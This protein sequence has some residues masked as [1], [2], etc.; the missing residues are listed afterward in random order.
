MKARLIRTQANISQKPLLGQCRIKRR[1]RPEERAYESEVD[2]LDVIRRA[3]FPAG[4][5]TGTVEGAA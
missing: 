5:E 3:P 2:Y 4:I 1:A